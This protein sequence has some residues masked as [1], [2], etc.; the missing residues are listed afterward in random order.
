MWPSR[1]RRSAARIF[2]PPQKQQAGRATRIVMKTLIVFMLFVGLFLC[3]SGVY[4]QR[5][6]EAREEKRVEYRFIPRT[7][8]EEQLSGGDGD[9]ASTLFAERVLPMFGGEQPWPVS[10]REP[11]PRP[12]RD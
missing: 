5:L 4:E 1:K 2:H 3:V 8:Y 12:P 9:G 11:L 6:K 7:M 10:G